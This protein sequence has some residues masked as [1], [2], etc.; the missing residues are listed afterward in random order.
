MTE[1]LLK[2]KG[3]VKKC[4]MNDLEFAF[5]KSLRRLKKKDYE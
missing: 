2:T 4:H 5:E 1:F 3:K